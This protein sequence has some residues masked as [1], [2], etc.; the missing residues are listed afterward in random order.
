MSATA[1]RP[2]G[3]AR[4]DVSV[5]ASPVAAGVS[6]RVIVVI[7]FFQRSSGSLSRALASIFAQDERENLQV[8]VVDD[9]SPVAAAAELRALASPP[10]IP[11]RILCQPNA[12]PGAA[13]NAGID[14]ADGACTYIAFLDSDDEWLPSHLGHA[15]RALSA[16][17]D[18]YFANHSL[19]G[20]ADRFARSRALSS[21]SHRR[22]FDSLP[23]HAYDGD[24][25]D[26]VI[27]QSPIHT[28]TVVYR[29]EAA[30]VLRFDPRLRIGEDE[31]F[32]LQLA[33]K[34][35]RICFSSEHEV[36]L[37]RGVNISGGE[38]G[39]SFGSRDALEIL[40]RNTLFRKRLP[41]LVPLNARQ[42][43]ATRSLC[44]EL[45]LSFVRNVLY[46]LLHERKLDLLM[47]LRY[48]ALAPATPISVAIAYFEQLRRT[49]C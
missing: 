8:I 24:F 36:R 14:A 31:L 23:L 11:V 13:R 18:F 46:R 20:A 39:G 19:P 17:F 10:P 1:I 27:G 45:Q 32:W 44:H 43:A 35:S 29:Y 42:R 25:F 40:L 26:L 41:K 37:G 4:K 21:V 34:T 5:A 28:S 16:G 12:G 38:T 9:G 33:R 49:N 47:L 3:C 7:P 22:L 30:A 2:V 48:L 15:R 6:P